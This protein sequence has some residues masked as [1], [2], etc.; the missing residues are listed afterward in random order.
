LSERLAESKLQMVAQKANTLA[1]FTHYT[2]FKQKVVHR[3]RHGVDFKKLFWHK[4]TYSF[5]KLDLFTAIQQ[6]WLYFCL[7]NSLAYKKA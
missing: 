4:F 5:C 7:L 6:I 3:F 1:Y 2:N